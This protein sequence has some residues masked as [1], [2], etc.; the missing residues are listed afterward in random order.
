MTP[1]QASRARARLR[2][3]FGGME[4]LQSCYSKCYLPGQSLGIFCAAAFLGALCLPFAI[5][6]ACVAILAARGWLA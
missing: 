4:I 1:E 2:S 6:G 3:R 5:R